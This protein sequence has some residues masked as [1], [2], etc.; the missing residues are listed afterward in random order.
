MFAMKY[1]DFIG[2]CTYRIPQRSF[3]SCR[4]Y[5]V[6][7][8]TLPRRL[9]AFFGDGSTIAARGMWDYMHVWQCVFMG[10]AAAVSMEL[11]FL[12]L[13]WK[14]RSDLL[15]QVLHNTSVDDFALLEYRDTIGDRAWHVSFGEDKDGQAVIQLGGS[16]TGSY[17]LEI[18]DVPRIQSGLW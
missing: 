6:L 5:L 9:F 18:R 11:V 10:I 15:W 12:W 16:V 14:T 2:A 8:I 3:R 13:Y 1:L 4:G 7:S 17:V